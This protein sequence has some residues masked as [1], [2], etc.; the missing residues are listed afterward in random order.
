MSKGAGLVFNCLF[1]ICF[2][3]EAWIRWK[4]CKMW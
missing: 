2:L 1:G 3:E 4:N